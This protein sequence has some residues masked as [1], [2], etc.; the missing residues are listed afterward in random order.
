MMEKQ[1]TG[2]ATLLIHILKNQA[3][4]MFVSS[5]VLGLVPA[6]LKTN[7]AIIL[8]ISYLLNAAAIPNPPR[9]SIITGVHIAAKIYFAESFAPNLAYGFT[10]ERAT[11]NKTTK[12]GMRRDV[13]KRGITCTLINSNS[14][15]F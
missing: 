11:P 2:A 8:A 7:V 9:S 12:N 3:T 13:T 5:T 6:L 1:S 15:K 14:T 10:S 4:N